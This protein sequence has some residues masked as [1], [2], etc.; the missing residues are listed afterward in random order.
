MINQIMESVSIALNKEFGDDYTIYTEEVKQGLTNPC[1]FIFCL[2][3][4]CN[5]FFN[6]KYFRENSFCIQYIPATD[7]VKEECNAVAERLFGCL[8]LLSVSADKLRG[9]KMNFEVVDDV[10]NFYVNYDFF[11]YREE[12]R[13]LMDSISETINVKG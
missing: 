7:D 10:L 1:F 13:E 6:K 12:S 3:P 4:S 8:E 5:L 2:N 11:V 9:T